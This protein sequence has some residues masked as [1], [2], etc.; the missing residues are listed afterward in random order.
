MPILVQ[1]AFAI[2]SMW[3]N[4]WMLFS[5]C[6]MTLY[7]ME[8]SQ[9]GDRFRAPPLPGPLWRGIIVIAVCDYNF[10]KQK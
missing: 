10:T 1:L 7:Q 5:V 4:V 3:R 6:Q 8:L 9:V 2:T